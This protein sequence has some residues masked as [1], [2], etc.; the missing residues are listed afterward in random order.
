MPMGEDEMEEKKDEQGDN[1]D[2]VMKEERDREK[3]RVVPF[4]EQG[5]SISPSAVA[6]V[7]TSASITVKNNNYSDDEAE[8]ED[9]ND[10][11][12]PSDEEQNPAFD[13]RGEV[14]PLP[15]NDDQDHASLMDLPDNLLSLP[16]SPCGPGDSDL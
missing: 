12:Y 15:F 5:S 9:D 10:D 11:A 1:I 16:I 2:L 8:G 3:S 7:A 13:D 14:T 6:D 4:D